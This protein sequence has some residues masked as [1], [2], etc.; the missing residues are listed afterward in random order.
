MKRVFF[1]EYLL[2]ILAIILCF[3]LQ[4]GSSVVHAEENNY[5][6]VSVTGKKIE[7]YLDAGKTVDTQTKVMDNQTFLVKDIQTE[8][9]FTYLGIYDGQ[10]LIGYL[11]AS[12]VTKADGPE[13]IEKIVR[14]YVEIVH[15]AE[16]YQDFAW[17]ISGKTD[18]KI[19]QV[20]KVKSNYHHF[21]GNVYLSL[22]DQQNQWIGYV[23]QKETI[24]S[25]RQSFF[26]QSSDESNK[27]E[28][29][30]KRSEQ[31]ETSEAPMVENQSSVISESLDKSQHFITGK[32][33]TVSRV[34]TNEL[35]VDKTNKVIEWNDHSS[36]IQAIA[37]KAQK[38]ANEASLYPSVM[39]AQAVLESSFGESKL[40]KEANNLF[41]IKYSQS[42]AGKFESYDIPSDEVINGIRVTLPASFRKYST[43]ADS[44]K[45]NAELLAKG[46]S[47]NA[48]FYQG[49]WRAN[50][51]TYQEATQAL[52]GKYAT[53]PA[54]DMKLNQL[55][56]TWNL[57]QYD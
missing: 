34:A 21:N 12:Q 18:E 10:D 8:G 14:D 49:T 53:D 31:A 2:I 42:D 51:A 19:G 57:S 44:L 5:E 54:Y 28:L 7:L 17:N 1:K 23:N 30:E 39:I 6:Y 24:A 9:I 16:I 56:E 46:L 29:V 50:A 3:E 33:S 40:S 37:P 48:K 4:L 45:D 35:T 20:F 15:S 41:G 55:I 52:T 11:D 25:D 32:S 47:Y 36:F 27:Q 43:I 22:F 38:L 13:G 26:T